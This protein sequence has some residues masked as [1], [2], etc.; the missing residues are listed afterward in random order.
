[1]RTKHFVLDNEASEL[2]KDTMKANKVTYELVP[3]HQHRRNAAVRA[4]CTLK[5]H[6]ISGL[7]TCHP[8]FPLREWDRFLTQCELIVNLLRNSRINPKLSVWA[9]LF[10]NH[11]FNKVPLLPSGTKV[12][13]HEKPSQRRSWGFHGVDGWYTGPAFQHY[14]CLTCYVTK[15][16]KERITDT[17]EVIPYS[18]P[19][20]EASLDTTLKTTAIKLLEH[21]NS[22]NNWLKGAK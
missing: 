9:Y 4:I 17:V 1:M 5:N 8:D 11:N 7:A 15:S 2:L 22:K 21:L 20:P 10:G 6:L 18:I 19:I 12:I 13:I 3:P 14:R 16:H